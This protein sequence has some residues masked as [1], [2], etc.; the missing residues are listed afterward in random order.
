M[1]PHPHHSSFEWLT[2][3]LFAA[4][5]IFGR[6]AAMSLSDAAYLATALAGFGS[7]ILFLVK[8]YAICKYGLRR[9]E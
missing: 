3:G 4:S 2:W 5:W 7:F 8:M 6:M 9:P 1:G